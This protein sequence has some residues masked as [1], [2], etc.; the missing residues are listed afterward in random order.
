M[1]LDGDRVWWRGTPDPANAHL[2]PGWRKAVYGT[3]EGPAEAVGTDVQ[4]HIFV[5]DEHPQLGLVIR[6]ADL[7]RVGMV[8]C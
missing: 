5:P 8:R 1:L 4:W 2:G 3:V 7:M 6:D